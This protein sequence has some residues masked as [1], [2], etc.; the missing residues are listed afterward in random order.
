MSDSP[1]MKVASVREFTVNGTHM[2][3]TTRTPDGSPPS[4][5]DEKKV[6]ETLIALGLAFVG[7]SKAVIR[8][9][10]AEEQKQ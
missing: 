6:S 9:D 7:E 2:K 4:A 10:C 3:M 5:E 1:E 8:L